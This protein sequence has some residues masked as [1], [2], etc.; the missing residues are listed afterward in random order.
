MASSRIHGCTPS[1]GAAA[2]NAPRRRFLSALC[3]A[4]GTVKYSATIAIR[5]HGTVAPRQGRGTNCNCVVA[6]YIIS[7]LA[8]N[9]LRKWS[10]PFIYATF[11]PW[12]G[13]NERITTHDV[14]PPS[15]A[16]RRAFL[17]HSHPLPFHC[18]S[19]WT[20]AS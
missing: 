13:L 17:G 12:E 7:P 2:A 3:T 20:V 15:A 9:A 8:M 16:R 4:G 19:N 14:M 1:L 11:L 18:R 5:R 10:S 6:L